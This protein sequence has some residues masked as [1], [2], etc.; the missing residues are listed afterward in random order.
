M[1]TSESIE[2]SNLSW[3]TD[4]RPFQTQVDTKYRK[5]GM[6]TTQLQLDT[7][8]RGARTGEVKRCSASLRIR[9]LDWNT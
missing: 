3:A 5:R 1:K 7:G 2:N 4:L 9:G 8:R 6:E